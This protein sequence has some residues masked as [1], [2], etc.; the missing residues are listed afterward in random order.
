MTGLLAGHR[1]LVTGG[2]SG[3][4]AATARRF[5]EEGASVAVLDREGDSAAEVAERI[6]GT[7]ITCDV[8]DRDALADAVE[9]VADRLGGLSVLFNNAGFGMAK[10]LH[11]YTDRE[12]DTL[13][14]VNLRSAFV[15]MRAAVPYLRRA[16]S[17]ERSSAVVNMSGGVGIRPTR[18]EAPYSAAKA[19]VV[20]LSKAAAVEY[21]PRIRVNVVS[22]AFVATRLTAP[23]LDDPELRRRVESRI[24]FDRVGT[25]EEVADVVVF[26]CSDL[27]RYVTG[28]DLVVDGGALCV[29]AQ[30]DDL[31]RGLLE[32]FDS[33]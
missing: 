3:I 12:W 25:P 31:L 29:S 30:A 17:Q 6:G 16:A 9:A 2:G 11:A 1:A 32:S 13:V 22:P 7:A 24:P 5:A 19:G 4:G 20:A 14:D 26:L 8:A 21:A 10:P 33:V 15:A 27:A 23:L 28:Q 18:G